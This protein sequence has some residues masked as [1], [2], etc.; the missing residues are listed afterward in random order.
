MIV[1][2]PAPGKIPL[3]F[4]LLDRTADRIH[5]IFADMGQPFRRIVPIIRQGQHQRQQPLCLQRQRHIPKMVIGHDR[6]IFCL[7]NSEHCHLTSS[8]LA[9]L[10]T[11]QQ[12]QISVFMVVIQI[13]IVYLGM[14]L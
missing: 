8:F 14:V 4:Q 9:S 10:Y 6:K 5:S 2:E 1:T 3:L 12:L 7:F 11:E 13:A